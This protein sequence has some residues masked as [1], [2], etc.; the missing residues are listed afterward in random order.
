MTYYQRRRTYKSRTSQPQFRRLKWRGVYEWDAARERPVKGRSGWKALKY[1]AR[2]RVRRAKAAWYDTKAIF[3][4]RRVSKWT[5]A[6][7]R[8]RCGH[9]RDTRCGCP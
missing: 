5:N 3:A 2:T 8:R 4:R 7:Q 1:D 9:Y 6:D